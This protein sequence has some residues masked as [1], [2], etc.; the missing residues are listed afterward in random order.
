[1]EIGVR[2]LDEFFDFILFFK[3]DENEGGVYWSPNP[4]VPPFTCKIENPSKGTKFSGL[5]SFVEY[6]IHPQ[7]KLAKEKPERIHFF[8]DI[9][10]SGSRV[11]G[12]RYKQ[13]DWLHE[14]LA[15]KFR[16]I[17]IPPLPGKQIAGKK[18]VLKVRLRIVFCV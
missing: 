12:R 4:N 11:V 10:I 2:N 17:C 18:N 1:V 8:H 7:V 5:K 16:F 14:Q 9:Q 3:Y 13:F 15:N 6:K